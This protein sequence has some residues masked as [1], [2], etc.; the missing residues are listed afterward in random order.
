[1]AAEGIQFDF[2]PTPGAGVA[3]MTSFWACAGVLASGGTDT[4]GTNI[5][6]SLAGVINF[7]VLT[8]ET[9]VVIE[10]EGVCNAAGT[11]QLRFAENSH[12]AGTAT[13]ESDNFM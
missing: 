5:S 13:I 7:T 11:L 10:F 3:T 4:I 2:N 8:G 9:C 6:T 1:Q 12:V